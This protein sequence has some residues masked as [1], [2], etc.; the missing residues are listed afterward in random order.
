MFTIFTIFT[1]FNLNFQSLEFVS[2]YRD[3][4]LQVDG[5]L[6]DLRNLGHNIYINVLRLKA[7]LNF[8]KW[9]YRC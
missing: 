5:N 7:Y 3:L 2:R 1:I 8:N 6:C 9:L 4:Q